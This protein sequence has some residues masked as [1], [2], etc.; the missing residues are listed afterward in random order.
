MTEPFLLAMPGE[1][2]DGAWSMRAPVD[3][4][5]PTKCIAL[6]PMTSRIMGSDRGLFTEEEIKADPQVLKSAKANT[7]RNPIRVGDADTDYVSIRSNKTGVPCAAMFFL[8]GRE[9]LF[10]AVQAED[11]EN[12]YIIF[13]TQDEVLLARKSDFPVSNIKRTVKNIRNKMQSLY[14]EGCPVLATE[15]FTYDK[16]IRRYVEA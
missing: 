16:S 13:I 7:S 6:V 10:K 8:E 9:K 5:D 15:V 12:Y 14:P 1:P 3:F 11:I 4:R 2:D